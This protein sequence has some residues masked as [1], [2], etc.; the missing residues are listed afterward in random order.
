MNLKLYIR[1]NSNMNKIVLVNEDFYFIIIKAFGN[2]EK[3]YQ[4]K[5]KSRLN[6]RGINTLKEDYEYFG[7]F[8]DFED[9]KNQH[10]EM[11]I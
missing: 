2:L 5:L 7:D 9:F 4:S 10:P 6:T 8:K 1:D 11:F 3:G